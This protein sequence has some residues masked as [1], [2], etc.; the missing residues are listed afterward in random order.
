MSR[1]II[2]KPNLSGDILGLDCSFKT[3]GW[4]LLS[5]EK[6]IL[7]AHGHIV[8]P[9]SKFQLLYRLNIVFDAITCLCKTFNPKIVSIEDIIQHM[10]KGFSS[11]GTITLLAALNRTIALSA[12]RETNNVCFYPVATIRKVI[13]NEIGATSRLE[14]EE[15]PNIIRNNLCQSFSD[16]LDKKGKFSERT[17]D[18]ADGIAAAWCHLINVK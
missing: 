17:M 4:G 13:K 10:S 12:W 7:I 6:K 2:L 1:T 14:K 11:A 15:I 16:V 8:P 18:E 5:I 3:I 9:S